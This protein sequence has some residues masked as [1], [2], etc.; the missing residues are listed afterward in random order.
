MVGLG[1]LA[2]FHPVGLGPIANPADTHFLPRPEWYYLPMFEWLKFWEGP[3]VV[4]A[5]VVIPGLLAA[6]FFLLPFLDRSLER[7]PW[8]RPIPVLAVAIV[9][10]G[11]IFLGVKSHLDDRDDPDDQRRNSL[12]RQQAGRGLHCRAV[13]AIHGVTWRH[14][15]AG[16]AHRPGQSAG[17]ARAAESSRR[18]DVPDA[19]ARSAWEARLLPALQALLQSFLSRSC[20]ALLHNP[21]A[22]MRAGHMPAVDIS[23][24][25]HDGA[26]RL[27]GSDRHSRGE[28][29]GNV[30]NFATALP[31]NEWS[32]D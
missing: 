26:A 31:G 23:P 25:R 7:R 18:T 32:G 29:A 28:R 11:T 1:F 5:V 4:F 16:S 21:N 3:K 9:I 15:P 27:P 20:I 13:S 17:I 10:A 22:A 19:M 8:R 30:R 6:L 14:G 12:C 24:G 2:Y